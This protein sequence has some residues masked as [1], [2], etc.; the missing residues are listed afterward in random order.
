[1]YSAG[2]LVILYAQQLHPEA[3]AN[4]PAAWT[5]ELPFVDTNELQ[6]AVYICL[7]RQSAA[8]TSKVCSLS[9]QS[10]PLPAAA[11]SNCGE[12][13]IPSGQLVQPEP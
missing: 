12:H 7:N 1:M 4:A 10:E 6:G 5:T 13:L 2:G 8:A 3:N 9:L 11:E